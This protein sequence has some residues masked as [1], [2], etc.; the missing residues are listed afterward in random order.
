M[1]YLVHLNQFEGPLDL[2]LHLIEQAKVDIKEIFISEITDQYLKYLEQ[3][4]E[5]DMEKAS[6]FISMAA[7]LVHIKSRSL[8]P[9][10]P[11]DETEEDPEQLLIRQL[12]EYKLFKEASEQLGALNDIYRGAYTKLPEEFLSMPGE[13]QWTGVSPEE[14]YAAFCGVLFK[15]EAEQVINPLHEVKPDLYNVRTELHRIRE[16]LRNKSNIGFN[17]L[18]EER[19]EKLKIIVIFMALLEMIAHNEVRLAQSKPFGPITISVRELIEDD[20]SIE[21]MD[22][23]I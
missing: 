6:E 8:L 22:E 18:F 10:A 17:E 2:L 3:I 15:E 14:L 13:V 7:T 21:Y 4:D 16:V 19:C 12:R 20:E 9:R 5:L 1:A 11:A 23:L